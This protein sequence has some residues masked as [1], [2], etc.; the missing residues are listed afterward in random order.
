M[1]LYN[2]GSTGR[3]P[4]IFAGSKM[5]WKCIA[6]PL[7]CVCLHLE[8]SCH[9]L[10]HPL[11]HVALDLDLI[12]FNLSSPGHLLV[13]GWPRQPSCLESDIASCSVGSY[14]LWPEPSSCG[15]KDLCLLRANGYPINHD[16]E[17][18]WQT[19]GT[20]GSAHP[21]W[22]AMMIHPQWWLAGNCE[23]RS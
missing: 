6:A 18:K 20:R 11:C 17:G 10:F 22:I 12:I 13:I 2:L 8:M 7:D 19:A 4:F 1:S 15:K 16:Y 3:H 14:K 23:L 9:L 5:T 21:S